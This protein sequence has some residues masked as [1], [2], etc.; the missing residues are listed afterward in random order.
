M[1]EIKTNYENNG[2]TVEELYEA[3]YKKLN[4]PSYKR[5]LCRI[6]KNDNSIMFEDVVMELYLKFTEKDEEGEYIYLEEIKNHLYIKKESI[7]KE[8]MN[9]LKEIEKLSREHKRYSFFDNYNYDDIDEYIYY[10]RKLDRKQYINIGLTKEEILCLIYLHRYKNFKNYDYSFVLR[11]DKTG[12]DYNKLN[13][14]YE[15]IIK[16]LLN[17]ITNEK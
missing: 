10:K 15:A 12:I 8:T 16:K 6:Y 14:K 2:I 1:K 4:N 17:F 5:I 11:K 9:M 7:S 13:Q 3:L